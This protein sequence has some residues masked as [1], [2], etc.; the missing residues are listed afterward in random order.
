MD[1]LSRLSRH[2]PLRIVLTLLLACAAA[3]GCLWLHTPLP[4]MIGPLAMTA[5]A[6]ML[7]APTLSWTPLRNAGQLVIA[8]ALGLYFTP[9]VVDL[10]A[11][12]WWAILLG[13][14]WALALGVAQALAM[15]Y[16]HVGRIA[17]VNR[18][19]AYFSSSIGGAS[20]MTLLAEGYGART[21]MVASAHSLR[22]LMV[23]LIVPFALQWSG[24][25]GMDTSLPGSRTVIWSGLPLLLGL[26]G[27][28]CAL[29]LRLKWSNPWF[30]GALA[31]SMVLTIADVRLSAIPGGL[32]NAAQMVIGVS[33][34]VRFTPGFVRAAPLWMAS[35]A[36]G[37]VAMIAA[38]AAFAWALAWAIAHF[39]SAPPLHP[40]TLMLGTAPGGIA[41]MAITAKVLQMG[42][43]VVTAFHVTRLAAVLMLTE[44]VYRWWYRERPAF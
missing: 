31:A 39:S 4:W 44:P 41:E 35:V 6:S 19:T 42:V 14:G 43:P 24:L 23:A 15:E 25:H 33:L 18:A 22:V 11:G 21:D 3:Q 9:Q 17:G 34:G 26:S 38:S 10:V 1:L 2:L 8:T 5:L 16:Q 36:L 20:E 29:M 27:L 30:V 32:S 12:L 28:G 40:A 13:V 37:T 7:G